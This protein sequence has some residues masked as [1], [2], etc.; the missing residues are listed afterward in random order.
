MGAE[1]LRRPVIV[2]GRPYQTD[3]LGYLLDPAEW[4][5]DVALA[6][7]DIEG[8]EM[9]EEHWI[10]VELVRAHYE[11]SQ[12][13]PEA[14]TLLKRMAGALGLDRGSRKYLHKLF[15]Y[16]YGPQVCKIAG[17]TLPRKVMADV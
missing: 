14:R 12:T 11:Q 1:V 13:V 15:P 6:I 5:R 10:V 9:A 3:Q 16:G 2:H 7:A 17:M 8:I 4:N